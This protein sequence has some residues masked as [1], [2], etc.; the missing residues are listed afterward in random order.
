MD[1]EQFELIA[2]IAAIIGWVLMIGISVYAV[3]HFI[4]K[5]W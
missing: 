3:I 2:V 4:I 5:Y 1:K